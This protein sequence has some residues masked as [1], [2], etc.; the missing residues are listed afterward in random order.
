MELQQLCTEMNV[1]PS[2]SL[3]SLDEASSQGHLCRCSIHTLTLKE[4]PTASTT[5]QLI[6]V[7]E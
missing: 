6:A 2:V 7:R 5:F 4:E 1:A 3:C